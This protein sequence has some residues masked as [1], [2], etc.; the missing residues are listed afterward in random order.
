MQSQGMISKTIVKVPK[1]QVLRAG[2]KKIK[3]ALNMLIQ[4]LEESRLNLGCFLDH[5][6]WLACQVIYFAF[7]LFIFYL[8]PLVYFY[9]DLFFF[10]F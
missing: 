4:V 8:F 9:L 7:S 6:V 10:L 5:I 2:R 1:R 3:N